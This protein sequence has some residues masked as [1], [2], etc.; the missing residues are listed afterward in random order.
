[1]GDTKKKGNNGRVPVDEAL[2][3]SLARLGQAVRARN[4]GKKAAQGELPLDGAAPIDQDSTEALGAFEGDALSEQ[5]AIDSWDM[6]AEHVPLDSLDYLR[7]AHRVL[8]EQIVAANRELAHVAKLDNLDSPEVRVVRERLATLQ[9]Q[10]AGL[11]AAIE[12][13]V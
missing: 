1:M 12:D 6:P 13:Q 10:R 8:S 5:D 4:N 2:A 11:D 9:A 3:A 7:D